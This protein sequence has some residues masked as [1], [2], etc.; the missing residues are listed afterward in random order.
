MALHVDKLE[1]L[2]PGE[3]LGEFSF[4]NEGPCLFPIG[5]NEEQ[6]SHEPNHSPEK[7]FQS[8][9]PQR[10]YSGSSEKDFKICQCIFTIS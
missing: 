2:S 4:F 3:E 10:W 6:E 7:Q 8:I 9:K 1:F 5:D